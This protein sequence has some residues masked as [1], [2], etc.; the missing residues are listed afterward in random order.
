MCACARVKV[1]RT[2]LHFDICSQTEGL[3]YIQW[4]IRIEYDGSSL[5]SHVRLGGACNDY[6]DI[7]VS[8]VIHICD[9]SRE[10]AVFVFT[11]ACTP[12]LQV[13]V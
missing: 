12:A 1:T 9:I 7:P 2:G 5:S 3:T 13:E 11:Y 10:R 4:P 6:R 8:G